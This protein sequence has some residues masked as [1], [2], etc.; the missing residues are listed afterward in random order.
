M[1]SSSTTGLLREE[2]LVPLCRLSD[3]ST[4]R[5]NIPWSILQ[6]EKPLC[7]FSVLELTL[8]FMTVGFLTAIFPTSCFFV[9][10][11]DWS[12]YSREST[13]S[14]THCTFQFRGHFPG[15]PGLACLPLIFLLHLFQ[16]AALSWDS[17]NFSCL[18]WNHPTVS[19]LGVLSAFRISGG[20]VHVLTNWYISYVRLLTGYAIRHSTVSPC[21]ICAGRRCRFNIETTVRVVDSI[22]DEAF[23]VAQN[24]ELFAR[25]PLNGQ[26]NEDTDAG[27]YSHVTLFTYSPYTP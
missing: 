1:L 5:W 24:K 3:V 9:I 19:S 12:S 23:I 11:V 16:V 2:E 4:I 18:V 7:D 8:S 14:H 26:L 15:K 22:Q 17:P 27:K 20:T 21:H 13:D 6:M 10:F 25:V